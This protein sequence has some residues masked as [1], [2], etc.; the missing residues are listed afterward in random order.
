MDNQNAVVE[1][2]LC[3]FFCHK[4]WKNYS[5][6]QHNAN[7]MTCVINIH[8]FQVIFKDLM[9]WD[10]AGLS[11]RIWIFSV[12]VI[13]HQRGVT[14]FWTWPFSKWFTRHVVCMSSCM[15]DILFIKIL[16][17]IDSIKSFSKI[18]NTHVY[19]LPFVYWSKVF[20]FHIQHIYSACSVHSVAPQ[21][22][23]ISL[24]KQQHL[25]SEFTSFHTD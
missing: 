23:I 20:C 13:G 14:S 6:A 1:F 16:W 9:S 22:V 10:Q 2:K 8:F 12:L 17:E 3:R 11:S 4:R 25:L 5:Q 15:L 21:L 19:C 18:P 7:F 24:V